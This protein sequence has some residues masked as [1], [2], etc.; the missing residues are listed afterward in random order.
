MHSLSTLFFRQF[1]IPCIQTYTMKFISIL[2]LALVH[3]SV[4]ASAYPYRNTV[5][6]K[7]VNTSSG[8]VEGHIA[9][10]AENVY[11]YL[12]IPYAQPPVGEL[13]FAAPQPYVGNNT[14]NGTSFVCYAPFNLSSLD[15]TN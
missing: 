3:S 7:P 1:E 8:P 4:R 11:E 2:E 14:I 5:T 9:T 6:A 10:N 13:R 12:G 15:K